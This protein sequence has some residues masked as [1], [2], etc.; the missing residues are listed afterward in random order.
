MQ[1]IEGLGDPASLPLDSTE[2]LSASSTDGIKWATPNEPAGVMLC[3]VPPG[4]NDYSADPSVS[5]GPDGHWYLSVLAGDGVPGVPVTDGRTFVRTSADG[6]TWTPVAV[7]VPDP[8][9][10]DFPSIVADPSTARRAWVITTSFPLTV[11]AAAVAAQSPPQRSNV[12]ISTTT[13]G[14]TTFSVPKTIHESTKGV[15]DIAARLVAFDDGSLLAVFAQTPAS[16]AET[17]NGPMIL[18]AARSA[19]HG[20]TWSPPVRVGSGNFANI[21]DPVTGT[22][23]EPH[24]CTFSLAAGRQH[25]AAL[26]WT[27]QL[28]DGTSAVNIASSSDGGGSWS[29]LDL[30]RAKPAFE[31]TVAI[32]GKRIA[33]TW[34]DFTGQ[35]GLGQTRSTTL[36]AASSTGNG[37]VWKIEALA[38]PFDLKTA[39]L[40]SAGYLGDYQSLVP[41]RHGFEATFTLA[42]PF[43]DNGPTDIFTVT[44]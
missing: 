43:A 8:G 10:D 27:T 16:T 15:L 21:T 32:N 17:G 22:A 20:V 3:E 9:D 39:G 12:V 11:V 35:P 4:L 44:F 38:G 25:T 23:Y 5:V 24:C 33:A 2:V 29:T 30:P 40:F 26:T 13:D 1:E 6:V 34:Y 41:W 37:G 36:W 19:D 28:A 14:G 42:K 31:P 18:Y 7:Q